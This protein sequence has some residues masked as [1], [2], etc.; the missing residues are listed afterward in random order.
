MMYA[1]R[2]ENHWATPCRY[3]VVL[4]G[5]GEV[6]QTCPADTLS[7]AEDILQAYK[8]LAQHQNVIITSSHDQDWAGF[9]AGTNAVWRAWVNVVPMEG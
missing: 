2:S 7:D 3:E 6:I 9:R 5:G 4:T 8:D 1:A